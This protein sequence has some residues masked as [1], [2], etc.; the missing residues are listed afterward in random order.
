MLSADVTATDL[1]AQIAAPRRIQRRR[2]KGWK[3]P[4]NT[5]Y[6]SRSTIY[7]NPFAGQPVDAVA[8]YTEWW[9]KRGL[10]N[11]TP[12]FD[13]AMGL[14]MGAM[15]QTEPHPLRGKNLAC[16]CTLDQPCH[17]DVLLEIA[18]D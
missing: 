6:V 5:V 1:T 2:T 7:G 9:N 11:G 17:A 4:P 8:F 12:I 13:D 3:M 10:I 15:F 18:N 14:L 16:W